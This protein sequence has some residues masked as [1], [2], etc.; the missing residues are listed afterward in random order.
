MDNFNELSVD[1]NGVK[2]ATLNSRLIYSA[3]ADQSL[4]NM[5][6]ANS[7]VS[8]AGVAGTTSYTPPG[9]SSAYTCTIYDTTPVDYV[10]AGSGTNHPF[11]VSQHVF[12]RARHYGSAPASFTW[13]GETFTV[14]ESISLSSYA[15]ENNINVTP[16]AIEDIQ[17][18]YTDKAVELSAVPCL[19]SRLHFQGLFHKDTLSGLA[20]WTVPQLTASDFACKPQPIVIN[21][22]ANNG[23]LKWSTPKMLSSLVPND[24]TALV[25]YPTYLGTGGD[26]GRPLAVKV[27][28]EY[29][30]VS[31]NHSVVK[32]TFSP[33][34]PHYMQGPDYIAAF[35]VIK[36]YVESKGDTVKIPYLWDNVPTHEPTRVKYTAASGLPDWEGVI[37]GELLEDSI[38]NIT[39]SE[40]VT[41]GNTVTGIESYMFMGC[42]SLTSVTIPNSVAY[43]QEFVFAQCDSLS[44]VTMTGKT[45]TQVKAMTAYPWSMNDNVM[46][47]CSD[48]DIIVGEPEPETNYQTYVIY[49]PESGLAPEYIHPAR[50]GQLNS[51]DVPNKDYLKKLIIGTGISAVGS[52]AF[53]YVTSLESVV[54]PSSVTSISYDVFYGDEG[55]TDVYC[56]PN[57]E[58]LSWGEDSCDD[59]KADGS[60]RCHVKAE[61]L[62]AYQEKFTGEVNV[63]FVGDLT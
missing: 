54:I 9:D 46:V 12:A 48:G 1:N 7:K 24:L 39:D 13:R 41:I 15:Q 51:T 16:S 27:G 32:S 57:P 36:A 14:T 62:T 61:Y 60:T 23:E 17:L 35:P 37:V 31:H 63:T 38:P 42:Y 43:I 56:Y 34:A 4:S 52:T 3:L 2:V 11:P 50:E 53:S 49:T 19:M 8:S 59:F 55:V 33:T 6:D 45:M 44:S 30:I 47:H 5:T 26:S 58:N 20:T 10:E 18:L 22:Y 40:M 29:A 21:G 28:D 25:E